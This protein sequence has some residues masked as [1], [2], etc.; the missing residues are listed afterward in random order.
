MTMHQLLTHNTGLRYGLDRRNKTEKLYAGAGLWKSKNLDELAERIGKL[1]R[2][3]QTG[4][5]SHYVVAV[6]IPGVVGQRLS[7]MPFDQYL[8]D[9]IF[10]PIGMVDTFFRYQRKN[11]IA[12]FLTII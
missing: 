3:Y 2:R 1:S 5:Q 11:W 4:E 8:K 12:C 7:G 10:E 9:N 6:D